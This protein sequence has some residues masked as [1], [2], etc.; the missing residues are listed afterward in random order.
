VKKYL[1]YLLIAVPL[2]APTGLISIAGD[3]KNQAAF[4]DPTPTPKQ[5]ARIERIELEK[6][7]LVIPCPPR[8]ELSPSL[9]D[10]PCFNETGLVDVKT[11]VNNPKSKPLLYQYKV[12][13]GR[14]IG[15]GSEVVWD[16]K[17]TRPGTYTISAVIDEGR[18]FGS[19]SQPQ[20]VTISDSCCC[21]MPCICPT[22]KI[23]GSENVKAGETV[24]FT[25][26]VEGGSATD[27]TYNWSIS[28]GEITEGQGTAEIKVK[29]TAEMTG[30]IKATVE[31][32]GSGMC[33]ECPSLFD[34]ETVE[35]IK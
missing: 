29:T 33:P 10:S 2:F 27:Y 3:C 23:S 26:K 4:V 7:E 5:S 1:F 11:I 8:P 35:I 28:Q 22:L 32:G 12:S 20:Q 31:I 6:N 13:G 21:L 18:G 24:T 15:Q 34:F 17:Y 19:E 30:F 9:A 14:I 16:L 25:A